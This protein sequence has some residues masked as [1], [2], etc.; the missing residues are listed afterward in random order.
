[1]RKWLW[2]VWFLCFIFFLIN[3]MP[4]C[5]GCKKDFKSQGYPAH[6]RSCKWYKRQLKAGLAKLPDKLGLVPGP[7]DEPVILEDVGEPGS[8]G[9]MLVDEVE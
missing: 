4:K 2:S 5:I 3:T 8:A 9:N 6:K 7:S 1:M